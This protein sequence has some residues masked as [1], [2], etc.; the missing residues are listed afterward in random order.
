MSVQL[1]LPPSMD[2]LEE[3]IESITA[4][5]TEGIRGRFVSILLVGGA[6]RGEST[7]DPQGILLGDLDILIVIPQKTVL[8]AW[9]AEKGC[10]NQL[11][12]SLG[13]AGF[14]AWL[15]LGFVFSSPRIWR[16]ASPLMWEIK[17]NARILSGSA[18]ARCLPEIGSSQ[19]IPPWEGVRLLAN[20]LCELL[21]W[22]GVGELGPWQSL[23]DR[24]RW[25]LTYACIKATL[26]CSEAL[27]I[28]TR[29]YRAA[30]QERSR[31]H[32][33]I[34]QWFS[35]EQNDHIHQAYEAKL[36]QGSGFFHVPIALQVEKSIQLVLSTLREFDIPS[37][38]ALQ[39]RVRKEKF[40]AP[41]RA[42]DIAFFL[43]QKYL[44]NTVALHRAIADVYCDGF[45]LAE[46]LIGHL[47]ELP[48]NTRL[49]ETCREIGRRFKATPQLVSILDRSGY[50]KSP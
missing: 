43:H 31:Q 9:I 24:M 44:G 12:S 16:L 48:G 18:E 50:S 40:L 10:R 6:A 3:K 46:R 11:K 22:L 8:S 39:G 14:P 27:Q 23:P 4:D 29:G 32:Q 37:S 49:R 7:F 33:K 5:I 38:R 26:A 20:R 36:N 25:D 35:K 1:A 28:K 21:N 41:G 30:Y 15:T 34:T 19:E 47:G 17:E 42:T 13:K 45:D 2:S